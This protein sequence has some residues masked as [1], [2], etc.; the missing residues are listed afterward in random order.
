FAAAGQGG[1]IVGAD[2]EWTVGALQP[3]EQRLLDLK[4]R[5]MAL[6]PAATQFAVATADGGVRAEAQKA[7]EITGI[8][9]V[10]IE[11][12]KAL[13]NPIKVGEKTT[14]RL[15][16][17]NPG[18]LPLKDVEVVCNVP[19]E[20]KF[21]SAKGPTKEQAAGGLVTFG[22]VDIPAQQTAEYLIE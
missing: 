1:R 4:V 14:Y 3:N 21:V 18:S 12:M 16:I 10:T 7:L 20:L 17:K 19:N 9:A 22:K 6:A 13:A 5:T 2:V 15:V 11:E 8:P